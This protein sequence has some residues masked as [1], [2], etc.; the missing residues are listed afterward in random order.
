MGSMKIELKAFLLFAAGIVVIGAMLF[1]PAGTLDC[2][3]A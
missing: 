2:W 1:I 3:Q